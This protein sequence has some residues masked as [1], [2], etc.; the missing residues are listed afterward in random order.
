MGGFMS[1]FSK[2]FYSKKEIRILILGL[3]RGH[4]LLGKG[5][6]MADYQ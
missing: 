1:T 6:P 5:L 4:V 3:V 2:L